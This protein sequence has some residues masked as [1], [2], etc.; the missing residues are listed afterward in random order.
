MLEINMVSRVGS[1]ADR[2]S[3]P[4]VPRDPRLIKVFSSA[5]KPNQSG[6]SSTMWK[7]TK[8]IGLGL[9]GTLA[10]LLLLGVTYQTV[11]TKIDEAKYPPIGQMV[12]VGG[13]Q[14]HLLDQGTGGPTVVFDSGAGCT[15]LDWSLIQPELAKSTRTVAYDRAGYAWS[16]ESP[17]ERTSENIAQELHTLLHNAEIPGPYVLVGH[18]FGGCTIRLFADMYPDEVVGLV[19]VDASHED[20][21][22]KI[23]IP[24][25]NE[26]LLYFISHTG[27]L[28]ALTHTEQYT[29][30]VAMFPQS[31]QDQT[32]AH[33]R[34]SK[35]HRVAIKEGAAL[36]KSMAQ[37]K[38]TGAKQSQ[39]PWTVISAAKPTST[40]GTPFPQEKFDTMHKEFLK[41]QADLV[42]KSTRG[43]Q[44]FADSDHMIT[45]NQPQVVVDAVLEQLEEIR[46]LQQLHPSI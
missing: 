9:I 41:L 26:N 29:K 14:L 40:E 24:L 20:I 30:S 28:R 7:W 39:L 13:Y 22:E 42:T 19:F 1:K 18:S 46:S 44:I 27:I 12:D 11:S 38:R 37:L 5:Q 17:L 3:L 15:S 23:D 34:A 25:M 4:E 43:K 36:E 16:D 21:L 31:V 32:L 2:H 10:V 45:R 6:R 33:G 8:I 35:L